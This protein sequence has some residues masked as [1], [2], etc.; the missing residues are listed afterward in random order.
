MWAESDSIA[1][2]GEEEK[3]PYAY[4]TLSGDFT[5]ILGREVLERGQLPSLIPTALQSHP[6]FR[7]VVEPEVISAAGSAHTEMA[8]PTDEEGGGASSSSSVSVSASSALM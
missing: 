2:E 3:V 4:T 1:G 7:E 5:V 8:L 6:D